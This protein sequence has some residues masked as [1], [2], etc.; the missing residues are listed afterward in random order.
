MTQKFTPPTQGA[1]KPKK[2]ANKP[3]A[4]PLPITAKTPVPI[5]RKRRVK[6]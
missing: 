1:H 3:V 2:P 4:Q 5:S 6:P